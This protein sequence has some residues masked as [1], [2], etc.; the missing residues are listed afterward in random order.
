[1]SA[2]SHTAE[3]GTLDDFVLVRKSDLQRLVTASEEL[4]SS[5]SSDGCEA[6]Y[7]VG[8]GLALGTL[9]YELGRIKNAPSL[10]DALRQVEG[11]EHDGNLPVLL[12]LPAGMGEEAAVAAMNHAVDQANIDTGNG[13]SKEVDY[14]EVLQEHLVRA[15]VVMT[16]GVRTLNSTPWDADTVVEPSLGDPDYLDVVFRS[17]E[18]EPDTLA[19]TVELQGD[20]VQLQV[21]DTPKHRMFCSALDITYP[22]GDRYG[23]PD[24]ATDRGG[25][26]YVRAISTFVPGTNFE[27][28]SEDSGDDT[29][30]R[31]TMTCRVHKDDLMPVEQSK[32]YSRES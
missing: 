13:S 29:P 11:N 28:Y 1:M 31:F 10:D 22:R 26:E 27:V 21:V 7:F 4:N 23:V 19:D 3:I 14:F 32:E 8:D 15:G 24:A 16:D 20:G 5:A 25:R 30:M 6:P 2:A 17:H 9:M 18:D 12:V